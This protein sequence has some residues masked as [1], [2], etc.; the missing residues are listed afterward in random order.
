MEH[1]S[2]SQ[3]VVAVAGTAVAKLV[4]GGRGTRYL[5]KPVA[6]CGQDE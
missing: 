1:S 4:G 6:P 5:Y 2:G 3:A